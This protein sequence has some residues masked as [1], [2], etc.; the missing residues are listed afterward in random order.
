MGQSF[1][2]FILGSQCLSE[3]SF[4]E[5]VWFRV[6]G[7]GQFRVKCRGWGACARVDGYQGLEILGRTF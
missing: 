5:G 3:I 7:L 1:R 6:Q 4:G 2:A